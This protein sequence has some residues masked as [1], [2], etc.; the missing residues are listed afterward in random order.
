MPRRI[1]FDLQLVISSVTIQRIAQLCPFSISFD[2]FSSNHRQHGMRKKRSY[3]INHSDPMCLYIR[4]LPARA[5]W[6]CRNL[7]RGK[8]SNK[9]INMNAFFFAKENVM[10]TSGIL[11]SAFWRKVCVVSFELEKWSETGC[12]EPQII[13]VIIMFIVNVVEAV[14]RSSLSSASAFRSCSYYNECIYINN[15]GCL[16]WTWLHAQEMRECG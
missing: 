16:C 7:I 3:I 1:E 10:L 14:W 6:N 9:R 4:L 11:V 8:I 2:W 5:I 13:I 15:S 12:T